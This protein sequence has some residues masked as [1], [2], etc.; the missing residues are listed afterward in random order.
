VALYFEQKAREF[1]DGRFKDMGP[2]TN[3]HQ[4][5][6]H[7]WSNRRGFGVRKERMPSNPSGKMDTNHCYID[8]MHDF[9]RKSRIS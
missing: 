9:C 8:N 4:S 1:I 5:S 7:I 3:S 2:F 6:S